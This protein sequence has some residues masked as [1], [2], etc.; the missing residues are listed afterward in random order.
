MI[1]QPPRST[2]FPYTT[3]FRSAMRLYEQAIRLAHENGFV[4]NEGVAHELAAGFYLGR[5]STTAAR[6]YLEGARSCVARWGALGKVAQLD[7]RYPWLREKPAPS[8]RPATIDTPVEQREVGTEGR[9]AQA[10]GT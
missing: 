1:R 9:D 3:L 6:A 5:G 7:Q 2:L 4:Q 8:L 10:G